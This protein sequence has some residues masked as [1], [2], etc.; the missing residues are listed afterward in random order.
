[1][2]MNGVDIASYQASLDC[3][4]AE[5]D[6]FII[7]A[8]QGIDYTNPYFSKHY[9]QA[10]AAG[11]LTGAYHYASGGDPVKEAD[12]FLTVVGHRAGGCILCLD[13]EHNKGKGENPAFNTPKEVEW[14]R[15][16]A[17]RIHEKTGVWPFMYMSA[18]V[19]RR[20]D[21]SPV[22]GNCPLWM[23]QYGSNEITGYQSSPW[24]D[25]RALGAWGRNIAIHQYSPSGSI[26]GY[27]RSKQH[28]LDLDIAYIDKKQWLAYA[29]GSAA[30]AEPAKKE[31]P[32]RTDSELAVEVIWELHGNGEDRRKKLGSRWQGAQDLVDFYLGNAGD[33][34]AAEKAYGKKHG[35]D[36]FAGK[37]KA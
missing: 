7:K 19:T 26:R 6:F 17:E 32:D 18:S 1:M 37:L 5:G 35:G 12:F 29:E 28:G 2:A 20:R 9:S 3:G 24:N 8:T 30:K 27:R 10:A 15:K 4:K 14:C 31:F 33:L 23:A 22:A 21:W 25:G 16:F 11:K 13:W 36:L 34:V